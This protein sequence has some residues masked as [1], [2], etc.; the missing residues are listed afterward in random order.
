MKEIDE[1]NFPDDVR[2][3]KDHEWARPEGKEFVVG[4]SDYAQ[5]QLGDIVYVELPAKG[6]HKKHGEEFGSVES[7]KAVSELF[8]PMGG[9][10]TALNTDLEDRPELVNHQPYTGGWM[11]KIKPSDPGEYNKLMDRK[12]YVATLKG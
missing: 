7:V 10:V 9:E 6:S 1:L 8:M 5:D 2:Y 4:I 11:I 3:S 12:A